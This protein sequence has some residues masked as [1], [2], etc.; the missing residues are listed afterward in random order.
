ML[1]LIFGLMAGL[2][3]GPPILPR[4]RLP[5]APGAGSIFRPFMD[6]GVAADG[7]LTA[8]MDG[9]ELAELV[10]PKAERGVLFGPSFGVLRA[11]RRGVASAD[12][13]PLVTILSGK[14]R[15]AL[16]LAAGGRV[17]SSS[18]AVSSSCRG[19]SFTDC[20]VTS[21]GLRLRFDFGGRCKA[22]NDAG[23]AGPAFIPFADGAEV[24]AAIGAGC[25]CK[26]GDWRAETGLGGGPMR[27]SESGSGDMDS[28][29]E[30]SMN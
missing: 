11:E 15:G 16:V 18:M 28:V 17:K 27:D 1:G 23:V 7:E 3:R 26:A 9:L 25:G 24:T 21:P 12:T 5:L 19:K 6:A 14:G 2:I 20:G 10:R 4:F 22:I 30:L 29:P 8:E 13:S